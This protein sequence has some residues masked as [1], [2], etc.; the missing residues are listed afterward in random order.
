[1]LRESEELSL[2]P[3]CFCIT[4]TT[5]NK[6]Y[7]GDPVNTHIQSLISIMQDNNWVVTTKKG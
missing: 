2:P 4:Y 3:N 7:P 6:Y 5:M 1:M